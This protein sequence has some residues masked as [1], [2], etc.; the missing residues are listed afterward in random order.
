MFLIA[1]FCF[2]CQEDNSQVASLEKQVKQLTGDLE[3][4]KRLQAN[5]DNLIES[6]KEVSTYANNRGLGIVM[7]C[8]NVQLFCV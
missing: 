8:R 2:S 7:V 1:I 5:Q 4:T 3:N 6:L